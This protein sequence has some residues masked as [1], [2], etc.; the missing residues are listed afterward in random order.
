VA[1]RDAIAQALT[2]A[3]RTAFALLAA[4]GAPS[5]RAASPA[6]PDLPLAD[7]GI[8]ARDASRWQS[9]ARL[10]EAARRWMLGAALR[11]SVARSGYTA[12]AV[13]G[14]HFH[15]LGAPNTVHLDTSSCRVLRDRSFKDIGAYHRADELWLVFAAPTL[16][17][18]EEPADAMGRQALQLVNEARA[19]G[20]RCGN[21]T[22]PAAGALRLSAILSE[23]ARQH[24][25]D[26]ARHHY[27]DHQDLGGHSPADRVRAVG[28][29]EQRVAENIAYGTLSTADAIAGWLKS[30]GHCENLMEPRFREMGIAFARAGAGHAEL[31]WVQLFADP[32]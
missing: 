2:R 24:A 7:C 21:R 17:P 8:D 3:L 20:Q 22:W 14:L 11:D 13:S 1:L 32:K 12:T 4:G 28:Y 18:S 30:P 27:F 10:D 9:D 31:F 6:L 15:G 5:A 16:L 23:V 26:M 25:L 19:R 29:R